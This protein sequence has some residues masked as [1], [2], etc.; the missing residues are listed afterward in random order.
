M[1]RPSKPHVAYVYVLRRPW[2]PIQ[3]SLHCPRIKGV[4]ELSRD[5]EV[6]DLED[7]PG[8]ASQSIPIVQEGQRLQLPVLA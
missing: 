4:S 7:I 6:H 5:L 2:N 3:T 8:L 1:C